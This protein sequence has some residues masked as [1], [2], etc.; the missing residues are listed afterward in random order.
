MPDE[1]IALVC[2]RLQCSD[3]VGDV[4]LT[5]GEIGMFSF[6][7]MYPKQ[8]DFLTA[9]AGVLILPLSSGTFIVAVVI[10]ILQCREPPTLSITPFLIGSLS[11]TQP[12]SNRAP[13]VSFHSLHSPHL[14]SPPDFLKDHDSLCI[15]LEFLGLFFFRFIEYC[16]RVLHLLLTARR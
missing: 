13:E 4:I 1:R 6:S 9:S 7:N 3:L 5:L 11:L 15:L 2:L 12:I 8:V 10:S 14:F 16:L